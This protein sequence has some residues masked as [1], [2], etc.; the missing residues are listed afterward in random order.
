MIPPTGRFLFGPLLV[1]KSFNNT[2]AAW[3]F[4]SP[5]QWTSFLRDSLDEGALIASL[6][7]RQW[8]RFLS[9][10]LRRFC[11]VHLLSKSRRRQRPRYKRFRRS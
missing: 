5:D 1:E 8:R 3:D 4:S 9:A 2:L 7:S 6:F 11:G 10:A